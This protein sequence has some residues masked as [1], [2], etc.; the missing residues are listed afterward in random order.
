M[1][2]ISNATGYPTSSAKARPL[3]NDDM[4]TNPDIYV[5]EATYAR[6]IPGKDV[7]QR[8]MRARMRAWTTFKTASHD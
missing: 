4:R 3:V 8:D 1:A 7:P 2:A 5:D 6:L